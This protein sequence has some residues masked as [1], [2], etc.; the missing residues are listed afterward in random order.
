MTLEELLYRHRNKPLFV[1]LGENLI[2]D[3]IPQHV[4]RQ[5]SFKK[6]SADPAQRS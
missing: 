2:G 1:K 5:L 3:L 6:G 4:T